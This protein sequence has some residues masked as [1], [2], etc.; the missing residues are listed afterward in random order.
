M[1][2]LIPEI[3]EIFWSKRPQIRFTYLINDVSIEA[4]IGLEISDLG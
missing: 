3:T 2:T 1:K 4:E